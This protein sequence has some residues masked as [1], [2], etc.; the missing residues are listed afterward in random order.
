MAR[1]TVVALCVRVCARA[2]LSA[3]AL[4]LYSVLLVALGLAAAANLLPS[5]GA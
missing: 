5:Y 2:T 4:S 1:G 3:A